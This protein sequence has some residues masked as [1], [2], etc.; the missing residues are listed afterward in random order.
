M[1]QLKA[2]EFLNLD[3]ILEDV[4]VRLVL[5]ELWQ[6]I[7]ALYVNAYTANHSIQRLANNLAFARALQP[8]KLGVRVRLALVT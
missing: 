8:E 3:A 2:T 7:T 1:F 5:R 4:L 6:H